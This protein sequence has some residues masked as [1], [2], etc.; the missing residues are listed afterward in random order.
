MVYIYQLRNNLYKVVELYDHKLGAIDMRSEEWD[1]EAV[2]T[3]DNVQRAHRVIE[4]LALC[5]EFTWFGTFTLDRNKYDRLDLPKFRKAFT[6]FLRDT[7]RKTGVKIEYLLVPELHHNKQGWHM[8]GLF[9]GITLD[10]LR[11]FTLKEKLPTYLRDKL[12]QGAVIYDWPGYRDRFGWV[13][14]EPVRSRDAAARYITKYL[15]KDAAP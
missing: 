14:I 10:Q 5:N 12:K 4:E 8:H 1:P 9:N 6:Q 13:D 7:K 2:K 11:P 3:S 15:T